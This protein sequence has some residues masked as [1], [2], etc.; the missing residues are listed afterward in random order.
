MDK[1]KVNRITVNIDKGADETIISLYKTNQI[2]A[3]INTDDLGIETFSE[4]KVSAK[5]YQTYCKDIII[6]LLDNDGIPGYYYDP[7]EERSGIKY[8][9][10]AFG[11]ACMDYVAGVIGDKYNWKRTVTEPNII[12]ME[13]YGDKYIKNAKATFEI[14]IEGFD[15]K[16]QVVAEIKS[17]QMCRP[18]IFLYNDMEYQFNITTITKLLKLL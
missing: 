4:S 18:R 14:L 16:I 8:D 2:L 13:Q 17:G 1:L 6:N 11:K 3:T 15:C 7:K 10:G 12:D 9:V 5:A